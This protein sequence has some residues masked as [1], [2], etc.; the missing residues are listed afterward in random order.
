MLLESCRRE[1]VKVTNCLNHWTGRGVQGMSF[2]KANDGVTAVG[3]AATTESR[4]IS[5]S[6]PKQ[7]QHQEQAQQ[8]QQ[9]STN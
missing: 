6:P 4:R 5:M 2:D 3:T 7:H 9:S 8:E 1:K